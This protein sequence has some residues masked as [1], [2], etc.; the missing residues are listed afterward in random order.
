MDYLWFQRIVSPVLQALVAVAIS[1]L[2]GMLFLSEMAFVIRSNSTHV[3]K[4]ILIVLGWIFLWVLLQDFNDFPTTIQESA[5]R[6]TVA[7][8]ANLSW[9]IL[10]PDPSPLDQ[11]ESFDDDPLSHVSNSSAVMLTVLLKS[12][13][14][15][16][17]CAWRSESEL[18]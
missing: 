18:T 4:I 13:P 16:N 17:T 3:C 10:S 12:L 15:V 2:L 7:D 11:P 1:V 8:D 9:P 14:F 5:G 6:T